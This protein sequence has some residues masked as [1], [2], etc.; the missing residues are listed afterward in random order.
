MNTTTKIIALVVT[1][2]TL[3]AIGFF[4]FS[5]INNSQEQRKKQETSVST[6]EEAPADTSP[7]VV[8]NTPTD[9]NPPNQGNVKAQP[10]YLVT[11]YTRHEKDY[12]G[13]DYV[14]EFTGKEAVE[15]MIEDGLCTD[16]ATCEVDPDGY[17]RNNNPHYRSYEISTTTPLS[18]EARG[19]IRDKAVEMG[20]DAS[21]LTFEDLKE[22]LPTLPKYNTAE[23]PFKEAKSLVYLDILG[24]GIIKIRER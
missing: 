17:I 21:A 4:T 1:V 9:E 2:A 19:V 10:A 15:A 3:V 18:I 7:E 20:K 14:M 22:V 24:E 13:V 12:I 8:F 6:Q 16:A 11:A 23:P 5:Q